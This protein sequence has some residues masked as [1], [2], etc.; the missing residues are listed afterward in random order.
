VRGADSYRETRC[1]SRSPQVHRLRDLCAL[2]NQ[3]PRLV[4]IDSLL[5]VLAVLGRW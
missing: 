3:C 1:P 5:G 4:G 2:A